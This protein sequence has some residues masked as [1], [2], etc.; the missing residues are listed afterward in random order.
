MLKRVVFL[1]LFPASLVS[2]GGSDLPSSNNIPRFQMMADGI[3]RG[4]QPDK[5]GFEFLKQKGIKTVV[6][7]RTENDEE[8]IV[9]QLGMNYIQ[10]AIDDP[11]PSSTIPGKAIARYFEVVNNP[12]NYPIFFHCRRGADRTG[13]MAA[14]YRIANQGWNASKA[15]DEARDIGMRWWYR[16]IKKQLYD[17]KPA[18]SPLKNADLATDSPKL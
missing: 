12:A 1:I 14:L 2:L 9:K 17:F 6:N 13:A 15:Y 16:A 7:L 8:T 4:G 3:F 10:I 5:K 11:R 18:A